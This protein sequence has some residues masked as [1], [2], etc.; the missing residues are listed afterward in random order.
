MLSVNLQ[1]AFRIPT[2]LT[3][4]EHM[5]SPLILHTIPKS[6]CKMKK[7]IIGI[8]LYF[9]IAETLASAVRK[10]EYI[11]RNSALPVYDAQSWAIYIIGGSRRYGN[12]S[13]RRILPKT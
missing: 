6:I 12:S 4:G 8:Y 7:N 10:N 11:A 5:I 2:R 1:K 3:T 13:M 9:F